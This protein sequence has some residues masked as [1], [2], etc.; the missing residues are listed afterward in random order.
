MT[1]VYLSCLRVT[2]AFV[3]C[4]RLAG[5]AVALLALLLTLSLFR[6]HLSR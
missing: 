4:W 1:P 3:G 2:V 6:R 5:L